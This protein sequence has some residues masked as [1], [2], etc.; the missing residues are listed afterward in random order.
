MPRMSNMTPAQLIASLKRQKAYAWAKYYEEVNENL[1]A[2]TTQYFLLERVV[3][4]QRTSV[5]DAEKALP[6]NLTDEIGEMLEKLKKD[7]ECPVCFG[8]LNRENLAITS[9]GHK[10]CKECFARLDKCAVCRRTLKRD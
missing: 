3:G 10:Y 8:R 2:N 6:T 1:E 9:C 7:I 5:E 4:N